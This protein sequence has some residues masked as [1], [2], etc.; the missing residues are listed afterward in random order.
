MSKYAYDDNIPLLFNFHHHTTYSQLDGIGTIRQHI[1]RAKKI[2]VPMLAISDHGNMNGAMELYMQCT[3][4]GIKPVIG[5][6]LYVV[7]GDRDYRPPKKS[8]DQETDEEHPD[9]PGRYHLILIAKNNVGYRNLLTITSEAH[10]NGFYRK[11]RT[12]YDIV[13]K[14]KEG[15]IATTACVISQFGNLILNDEFDRCEQLMRT[16]QQEF[17]DDF[18]AELQW[19]DSIADMQGKC[20]TFLKL[21]ADIL[22]VKCITTLDSHYPEPE[23]NILQDCIMCMQSAGTSLLDPRAWKLTTRNLYLM[24]S[25][26]VLKQLKAAKYHEL[27][28]SGERVFSFDFVLQTLKN[29]A[30]IYEKI[31]VEVD[32]DTLHFPNLASLDVLNEKIVVQGKAPYT[33]ESLLEAKCKKALENWFASV[34]ALQGNGLDDTLDKTIYENRLNEELRVICSKGFAPYFLVVAELMEDGRNVGIYFGPARGSAAGCLISYLLK[35]TKIDPLEAKLSF[36]RFLNELREDPPDIDIDIQSSR[37]DEFLDIVRAKYGKESVA[38]VGNYSLFKPRSAIRELA[39]VLGI[40]GEDFEKVNKLCKAIDPDDEGVDSDKDLSEAIVEMLVNDGTEQT[41]KYPF[42]S[43]LCRAYPQLFK[44]SSKLVNQFRTFSRHAGGIV[45]APTKVSDHVPFVRIGSGQAIHYVTG[46]DKDNLVGLVKFD[47]LGLKECDIIAETIRLI[48]DN[49]NKHIEEENIPLDNDKVFEK[50][51]IGE[52]IGIFQFNGKGITDLTMQARPDRFDDLVALNALYRPGPMGAGQHQR[53][54]RNKK[55]PQSIAYRHPALKEI[56]GNEYGCLVYQEHIMRVIGYFT[57]MTEAETDEVRS[58]MKKASKMRGSTKFNEIKERFIIGCVSH[59]MD[60]NSANS[61]WDE[62]TQFAAY[63]FNRSHAYAYSYIA[64]IS[65]WLKINYPIEFFCSLLNAKPNADEVD[66]G[67]IKNSFVDII[68]LARLVYG[69]KILNPDIN[70]SDADC[71]IEDGA[72]R[73]GFSKIKGF[74]ITDY[75]CIKNNRPFDDYEDFISRA[76]RQATRAGKLSKSSVKINSVISLVKAGAFD[77]IV[78][79]RDDLKYK[80]LNARKKEK[81]KR[82]DP[83]TETKWTDE[84]DTLLFTVNHPLSDKDF[85]TYAKQ[86]NAWPSYKIVK[87]AN[88]QKIVGAGIIVEVEL[89]KRRY[90]SSSR[91]SQKYTI[92]ISDPT[93]FYYAS[94]DK[95]LADKQFVDDIAFGSILLIQGKWNA[96]YGEIQIRNDAISAV[97]NLTEQFLNLLI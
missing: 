54:I 7:D 41:D 17:G 75:E 71:V 47:F 6:E 78:G 83:T 45:I 86:H 40:S 77:S 34:E 11:P 3:E 62:L 59:D 16:F 97:V 42:T 82:F 9:A 33:A 4:A 74:G 5:C 37:R 60:E 52:T 14:Y 93:G 53:F 22:G 61:L 80:I 72:I 38:Q 43:Y 84:L 13:F 58:L 19:H 28:F 87:A 81:N 21:F 48:K 85:I 50:F 55:N 90:K 15:L 56:L 94:V 65:M 1:A 69:I 23:D 64:Y 35:I 36:V 18:Y 27:E 20:N 57:D 32:V 88:N 39:K 92:R 12:C 68:N 73:I 26:D 63:S 51:R 46:Y 95:A 49:Q 30:E 25:H 91:S 31:N 29:T 67:K 2:G 8:K 66:W 44:L 89:V 10:T 76:K 96:F 24:S 70:K 79:S